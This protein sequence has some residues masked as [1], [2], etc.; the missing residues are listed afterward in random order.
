[1]CEKSLSFK[2]LLFLLQRGGKN[3]LCIVQ[4]R[5]E[6]WVRRDKTCYLQLFMPCMMARGG[7]INTSREGEVK[8]DSTGESGK[9]DR[10]SSLSSV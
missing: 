9:H 3:N 10:E 7:L 4:R 6:L 1:M 2:R 5:G 8:I